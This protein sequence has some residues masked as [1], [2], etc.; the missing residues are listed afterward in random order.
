MDSPT[1]APATEAA[2]TAPA[3]SSSSSS[4]QPA[5][6]L[7]KYG[8]SPGY[9]FAPKNHELL[10]LLAAR[11]RG[12]PLPHPLH[13]IFHELS[14]LDHHP[15]VLYA[16]S[17][18]DEHEEHGGIYFFSRREFPGGGGGGHAD[19]DK[20]K[21]APRPVRACRGGGGGWKPSGGA[22][23]VSA[24]KKNGASVVVGKMV[25][26]VFYER[27]RG[28]EAGKP[29]YLKTNWG[30][31][32][33]TPNQ[34][35]GDKCS[36]MAV[37]RLYKLK[38]KETK[39]EEAQQQHVQQHANGYYQNHHVAAILGERQHTASSS[40]SSSTSQPQARALAPNQGLVIASTSQTQPQQ[41]HLN[42]GHALQYQHQYPHPYALGAAAMPGP[43]NWAPPPAA[44]KPPAHQAP[45]MPVVHGAVHYAAS[46]A[47]S[48]SPP[49]PA[50]TSPPPAPEQQ[51]AAATAPPPAQVPKWEYE[52][53][54]PAIIM[55]PPSEP[56]A[57]AAFE[58]DD[59]AD[60]RSHSWPETSGMSADAGLCSLD[61]LVMDDPFDDMFTFEELMGSPPASPTPAHEGSPS[62]GGDDYNQAASGKQEPPAML[63]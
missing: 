24:K 27:R 2:A 7:T 53:M 31:H 22:R 5:R 55:P 60:D 10:A 30:I 62:A 35:P 37:Y 52:P 1:P 3:S 50:A 21:T 58:D 61:A 54:E 56:V 33:F 34:A 15:Q 11:L 14:I 46:S 26:L 19:G 13:L 29:S 12:L 63:A 8:F 47:S 32:E 43:S 40:S 6:P 38:N 44:A 18:M 9:R 45:A 28:D 57:P 16:D 39:E 59:M 49:P 36:D 4:A 25:T 17:F 41:Q 48:P 51:H 42:A 23:P 20:H